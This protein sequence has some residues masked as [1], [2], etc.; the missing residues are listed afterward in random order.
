M[1]AHVRAKGTDEHER[2]ETDKRVYVVADEG[3]SSEEG[4]PMNQTWGT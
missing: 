3:K 2:H 1:R 4:Q